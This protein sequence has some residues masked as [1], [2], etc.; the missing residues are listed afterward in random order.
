MTYL[1]PVPARNLQVSQSSAPVVEEDSYVR[2]SIALSDVET[3]AIASADIDI[4]SIVVGL[5]KSTGGVEPDR[6]TITQ[7]TFVKGDG[8]VYCNYKF[9][10]GEW[11]IGDTY[12][13]VVSGISVTIDDDTAYVKTCSWSNVILEEQN[14]EGKIDAVQADIGNPS[15][16]ANS[17]TIEAMLGNADIAG[18][19]IYSNVR[20]IHK[21]PIDSGMAGGVEPV[22]NTLTDILHK[23]GSFTYDNTTDS[24]EAISDLVTTSTASVVEIPSETNAKTFNATALASIEAEVEDAIQAVDL[25]HILQLDGATQVYP[26]NCATDSILA[27]ILVKSDPAVPSAFNNATDS[28]EAISDLVTALQTDLDNA[29]DGLGA[30]KTLIDTVDTVVD[31]N[32]TALANGTYGLSAL[33]VLIA[34]LQTDLDNGTDGLGALKTLID[35]VDTVVD[36]NAT[37]LTAGVPQM[38]TVQTVDGSATQWTPAAHRL[39][40]VTGLVLC[41]VFAV[42]DETLTENNGDETIEVGIAN[43]TA[44]LLSQYATPLDFATGDIW[45]STTAVAGSTLNDMVAIKDTDI[46]LTVAGTTGINDG[47]MTFY[48][49]WL[50]VSVGATVVAAVWD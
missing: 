42:T 6:G 18:E 20:F 37:K 49:Q 1:S 30:L 16:R 26:E 4:T 43:N 21:M 46:D 38:A 36:S 41:R 19:T 2:F 17:Q 28:L 27:K 23:N 45:G 11:E 31:G 12:Q 32:A 44:L 5:D 47:Q 35:T 24:L 50:P 10:A 15:A 33:Q 3:G 25:D 7:P 39:F 29:T 40:T 14:V 9:L 8:V 34:A 22:T 48:C 13:L